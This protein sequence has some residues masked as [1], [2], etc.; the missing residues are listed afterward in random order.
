MA[1]NTPEE[2]RRAVR[3]AK[4]DNPGCHHPRILYLCTEADG[5]ETGFCVAY[6]QL[7]TRAALPPPVR[8]GT[9]VHPAA[10]IPPGPARPA[11][12]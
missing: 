12:A 2:L 9:A 3:V 10:T 7:F 8:I 4:A 1:V 11:S 6:P 5:S